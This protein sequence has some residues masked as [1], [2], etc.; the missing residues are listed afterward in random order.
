LGPHEALSLRT[1]E[2][3]VELGR[4][5]GELLD[6][7]T[8]AL[9]KDKGQAFAQLAAQVE[10]LAISF[11]DGLAA[12]VVEAAGGMDSFEGVVQVA[13]QAGRELGSVIPVIASAINTA[14][15][16]ASEFVLALKAWAGLS[17][18]SW[19]TS[20]TAATKLLALAKYDVGTA[21]WAVQSGY[22]KMAVLDVAAK[23]KAWAAGVVTFKGALTATTGVLG[24]VLVAVSLL[25]AGVSQHIESMQGDIDQMVQAGERVRETW[26]RTNEAIASGDRST[27]EADQQRLQ[28]EIA[29][30]QARIAGLRKEM[31]A[32]QESKFL[33][34][35]IRPQEMT[36]FRGETVRLTEA[37]KILREEEQQATDELNRFTV[38]AARADAALAALGTTSQGATQAVMEAGLGV[39]GLADRAIDLSA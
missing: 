8:A 29:K 7:S 33:K 15:S 36:D 14:L 27:I 32:A 37:L 6:Q 30:T 5:S 1:Q 19:L 24:A 2:E 23:F 26:E 12:G 25:A 13:I 18:V 21:I 38:D 16:Y 3:I 35:G 28:S 20:T 39:A 9:A 10:V 31:E 17:L 4:K 34:G 11:G 22:A